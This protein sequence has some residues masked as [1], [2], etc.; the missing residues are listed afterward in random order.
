[1]FQEFSMAGQISVEEFRPLSQRGGFDLIDVRSPSEFYELHAVGRLLMPLDGLNPQAIMESRGE[2]QH[3]PLYLICRSGS[4]SLQASR[5]F[6]QAGYSNVICIDGGTQAWQAAGLPVNRG[7]RRSMSIERQIRLTTGLAVA[8]CSLATWFLPWL[9]FL[10]ALTGLAMAWSAWTNNRSLGTLFAR[11]PWNRNN[12][13]Q[14][15]AACGTCTGSC[16]ST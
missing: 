5:L 12:A 14:L 13:P 15:P 8:T 1:M 10:P 11:L 16:G 6:E 2:R 7:I 3:E 4:R 9:C